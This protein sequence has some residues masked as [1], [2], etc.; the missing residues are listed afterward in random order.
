MKRLATI[1]T[2]V[3]ILAVTGSIQ[4]G[5][6]FQPTPAD[7]NGLSHGK[8]YT[9]GI[10]PYVPDGEM[11][12]SAVL[13]YKNIYNWQGEPSNHMYTHLLDNPPVGTYEYNDTTNGD[14]FAGQGVLIGDWTD[15]GN[16][17]PSGFDLVYVFNGTQLAALNTY[18][19]DGAFGF[20]IDPDCQYYNDGAVFEIT[21]ARIPAPGALLLGSLGT[22]LVGYLRRRRTL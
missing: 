8:Y 16:G 3:L 22:M 19:A 14:Q 6:V 2:A 9:W 13:T 18:A 21:T 4:A 15:P 10:A 20:G 7:L 17:S 1:T 5:I 11:I 12:D